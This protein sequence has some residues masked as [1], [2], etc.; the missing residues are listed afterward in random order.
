MAARATLAFLLVAPL[1]SARQVFVVAPA[2]GPGVFHADAPS[3]W[4]AR[5]LLHGVLDVHVANEQVVSVE[6]IPPPGTLLASVAVGAL[7]GTEAAVL[8]TQA[9]FVGGP[10]HVLQLGPPS[11]LVELD[12]SR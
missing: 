1:A 7:P 9:F 5:P 4:T 8:S 2:P 3:S 12:D 6:T 10:S 11:A